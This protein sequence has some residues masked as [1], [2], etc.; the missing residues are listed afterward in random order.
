MPLELQPPP[1]P[2]G[3]ALK[4]PCHHCNSLIP[5]A[6]CLSDIGKSY[7]AFLKETF[8]AHYTP[9]TIPHSVLCYYMA[10]SFSWSWTTKAGP[11]VGQTFSVPTIPISCKKDDHKAILYIGPYLYSTHLKPTST[12]RQWTWKLAESFHPLWGSI[13]TIRC[14]TSKAKYD[15]KSLNLH[16]RTHLLPSHHHS[17][18]LPLT[19]I[20]TMWA[21]IPAVR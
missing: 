17:I 4:R 19:Q 20:Q 12:S 16:P 5:C 15:S 7:H 3:K 13:K 6:L 2:L 1:F 21:L 14:F 9:S 8:H 18:L 10:N 11:K